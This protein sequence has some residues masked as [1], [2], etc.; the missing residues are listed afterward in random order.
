MKFTSIDGSTL[1]DPT[2]YIQIVEILNFLTTT[3]PDIAF[4][5]GILSRFMHKS[6][7][8]HCNAAKRVLKYLQ[9]TQTCGIKYSKVVDSISPAIQILLLMEKRRMESLLLV[10]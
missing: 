6:C 3:R 9:R 2:K 1:K 8:G 7:E 5:V 10:I 4:V